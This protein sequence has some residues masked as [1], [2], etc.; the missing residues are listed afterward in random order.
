MDQHVASS[1]N[2]LPFEPNE[3]LQIENITEELVRLQVKCSPVDSRFPLNLILAASF[4]AWKLVNIKERLDVK[5]TDFQR[6]FGIENNLVRHVAR[7]TNFL[8]DLCKCIPWIVDK[9]RIQKR[10]ICFYMQDL[11]DHPNTVVADY[12]KTKGAAI[13]AQLAKQESDLVLVRKCKMERTDFDQLPDDPDDI[14][15]SEIDSYI[16]SKKE[17]RILKKLRSS[18]ER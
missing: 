10:T 9:K 2:S 4:Y 1:V 7:L 3:K 8:I 15:D 16:R 18:L 13:D 14:S 17:V 6:Q 5:L 11:L 12:L